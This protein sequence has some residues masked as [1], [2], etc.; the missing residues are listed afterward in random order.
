L[1]T[2]IPRQDES[3]AP[4]A[5]EWWRKA[6][7]P[8]L[9]TLVRRGLDHSQQIAC[10]VARLRHHDF[11]DAQK[12]KRI[13]AALGRL[14]GASQRAST[15]ARARTHEEQVQRVVVQRVRVARQIALAYV[16][17]RRLQEE[18]A[19]RRGWRDQYK[20]NAEVAVF[21]REAGL[22]SAI[23]GALARSQNQAAQGELDFAERRLNDAMSQ[24]ADLIGDAPDALAGK[25][26]PPGTVTDYPV[27]TL[28][29]AGPEDPRRVALADDILREARLTQALKEARQTVRDARGAYRQGAG[30]FATLY[31]AEAAFTAMN[32]ALVNARASRMM[33]T[34][35]LLSG[36]DAAW[37]RQGLEQVDAADPLSRDGTITVTADCD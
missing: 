4:A 9:T 23:D 33:G 37:A 20:D 5:P 6:G 22:V 35:D 10:R 34:L 19:L 17:V 8:V 16:E 32:L 2:K 13:G 30:E 7:D 27:D 18:V 12:T 11:Q 3:A 31:A 15:D 26:G 28:A 14:L 25:L 1:A 29:T 21:R 24:L 36:Q